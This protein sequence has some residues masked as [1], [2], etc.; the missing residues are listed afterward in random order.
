SDERLSLKN[1]R[2]HLS[3]APGSAHVFSLPG[4]RVSG[5]VVCTFQLNGI[6][7][8]PGQRIVIVGDC[9]ELGAWDVASA[10]G[11]EFVNCNTWICEVAFND[12][13]GDLI[14]YK[15]ALLDHNNAVVYEDCLA[16]RL[17]LPQLGREKVDASWADP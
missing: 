14:H 9:Q 10:Y 2:L 11:M 5:R 1:G 12:S 7:T 13:A 6:E 4:K 15:Y 16:R 3:L 8:R 17:L